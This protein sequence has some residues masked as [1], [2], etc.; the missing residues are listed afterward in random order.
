MIR[1]TPSPIPLPSSFLSSPI[2]PPYTRAAMAQMRAAAPSTYHSLLPARTPPLLPIPLPAP[3]TSR[4]ADI[5]K[6][7]MPF[8]KRILLTAP[9]LTME[10]GETSAIWAA[11][12]PRSTMT[13]SVR[14][15][16]SEDFYSQHQDAREDSA[17]VRA[18]IG[19]LRKRGF[20]SSKE[21][22]E[23]PGNVQGRHVVRHIIRTQALKAGARV[24]TLEDTGS[25]S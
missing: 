12:R 25:S 13:H 2:R 3:S 9:I 19:V 10:V 7:D 23:G 24:D 5:S 14:K 15:R 8:R 22:S 21:S 17:S 16:E 6:A 1:A 20:A 4:R 11:R 18:K